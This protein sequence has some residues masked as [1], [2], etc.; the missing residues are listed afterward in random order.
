MLELDR[1]DI[2]SRSK[3]ILVIESTVVEV[4]VCC[5]ASAWIKSYVKMGV[6]GI[7]VQR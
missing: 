2:E 5:D 4:M 1:V 3:W 7:G 6:L